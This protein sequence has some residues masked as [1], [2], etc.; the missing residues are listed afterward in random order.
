VEILTIQAQIIPI[1]RYL[2]TL[3]W[4]PQGLAGKFISEKQ[5]PKKKAAFIVKDQVQHWE[6]PRRRI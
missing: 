4:P 2:K 1:R 5:K 3:V 6:S